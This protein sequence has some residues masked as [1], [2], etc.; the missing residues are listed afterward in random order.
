ML[1]IPVAAFVITTTACSK[2]QNTKSSVVSQKYVH[3]YGLSLSEKEWNE[4]KKDGQIITKTQ[5]GITITNTYTGGILNGPTTYTFPNSSTIK[6]LQVY[7]E[8]VLSKKVT[9]DTAG[10]PEKEELYDLN[11]KI[12][13]T[14][15][16]E[17]GT[18]LSIEEYNNDLLQ[19]GQYFNTSH[20]TEG[21]VENGNGYRMK[22]DRKGELSYK[23][24]IENGTLISRTTFHNNGNVKSQA[25]FLNYKLHGECFH[26]STSGKLLMK[27]E[28]KEGTLHGVKVLFQNG[29]KMA[30]I[31]FVNGRKEGVEHRF[32]EKGDLIADIHWKNGKKHGS[33]TSFSED[34]TNIKWYFKGTAVNAEKFKALDFRDK[35]VADLSLKETLEPTCEEESVE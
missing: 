16:D 17:K 26:Y 9:Y 19:K 28:W 33:A 13:T 11:N 32:N 22:R 1:I 35:L 18:P 25:S 6:E 5:D 2:P 20:E 12:V 21:G 30:E 23:D 24:K 15:W 29:T 10:M 4:R 14:I 3:K 31:P 34:N 27:T 7:N 8:G